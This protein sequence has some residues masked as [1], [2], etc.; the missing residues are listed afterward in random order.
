MNTLE[1]LPY[2]I[3]LCIIEYCH[4][5]EV[6]KLKGIN[7]YFLNLY[8]FSRSFVIKK[9][10]HSGSC[11]ELLSNTNLIKLLDIL[12]PRPSVVS[13]IETTLNSI[14][15]QINNLMKIHDKKFPTITD[16]ANKELRRLNSLECI[17]PLED[18]H[19]QLQYIYECI[20]RRHDINIPTTIISDTM[21][22]DNASNILLFGGN[23][24]SLFC[25][26]SEKYDEF[27][28]Y[29]NFKTVQLSD[30]F[31]MILNIKP[32][33]YGELLLLSCYPRLFFTKFKDYLLFDTASALYIGYCGS[34]QDINI[35]ISTLHKSILYN[36]AESDGD[37]G[38]DDIEDTYVDYALLMLGY[39]LRED[40]NLDIFKSLLTDVV[41][42]C[43]PY[44]SLYNLA[45]IDIACIISD[46]EIIESNFLV[47][48]ESTLWILLPYMNTIYSGNV[49]GENLYSHLIDNKYL[50]YIKRLIAALASN[51]VQL[52]IKVVDELTLNC[53]TCI[54]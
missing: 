35:Y 7:Q 3:I 27:S 42:E 26:L 44:L 37:Y 43:I 11:V 24:E 4:P 21:D 25:C 29:K 36:S 6:L 51:N 8:P 30:C 10:I 19:G 2:E 50:N 17:Y 52:V 33:I 23:T 54:S 16:N 46:N 22:F 39:A 38:D 31:N 34:I 12:Y 13:L 49:K 15:T 53:K 14:Q 28:L 41:S 9:Y 48:E 47:V 20:T 5:V 40:K 1:N 45:D 32:R 18:L